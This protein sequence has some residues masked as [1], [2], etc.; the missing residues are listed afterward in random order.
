MA[1]RIPVAGLPVLLSILQ[2]CLPLVSMADSLSTGGDRG[3]LKWWQEARFGMF[4]HWGPVSLAGTEIGWSRGDQVSTE[5]YD[6]LYRRFNPT[7]FD[8]RAWARLAKEAG[9]KY[10]VFTTKHHDGFCNWDTKQTDYNILQTPFGRDVVK[11][12]AS[13]CRAE[14][15]TFCAYHSICDWRH[16]DY[17][18]GSPGGRTEKPQPNMDRYNAYLKSQLAELIQN[19]GPLG[20][21]WF[22]GEW[23]KPWNA[24]RGKDLYEFCR[25]L[26][27][28]L[29]INN[30]VSVGRSGMA[31]ATDSTAD[32]PGDYDTPEQEIGKYQD[33]RPWETCMTICRQWAW[34][35]NDELKSL[36]E[37]LQTLIVCTAGDGNLLFNVGPMPDGQ[38]EPRQV[39]RLK[40]MGAWLQTYGN[41][42]YGTR[43]GPWKPA[44]GVAST[45]RDNRVFLHILRG[46]PESVVLPD[47]PGKV[48]RAKA[49]TGG[50]V[51][52]TQSGGQITL[53]LKP[54][55]WTPERGA[56]GL[57]RRGESKVAGEHIDTIIA[58]ELD[59]SAMDI[60]AME[61]PIRTAASASNTFQNQSDYSADKAFDGNPGT[62]WATDS[63]TTAA[64][65]SLK[66]ATPQHLGKV[67]IQEAYPGRVQQF[68]LMAE[69]GTEWKKV[70]S[71]T[72][73]GAD[74][75][76]SFS[77]V[78][79]SGLRLNILKATDGPTIKEIE[80]WR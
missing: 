68:E 27:P 73:L 35:P 70:S 5:V 57:L 39:A 67:R 66:F 20:I 6:G 41:T 52:V 45:R 49:L 10:L 32:N 36:R 23:E 54:K 80:F 7:N 24:Q 72:T 1:M 13:A 17:P 40:Q 55:T 46:S 8:A 3:R 75:R 44:A 77:P 48:L 16:P 42:I 60:P 64:W 22:D 12:L 47:L 69:M 61:T 58:L 31:G 33:R 63:G 38:I 18:L 53:S 26:Q 25:K 14:G 15:I 43:G 30:R 51:R 65:V 56:E 79:A 71:G 74:Y 59:R 50:S 37:C 9:M 28:S 78:V 21:L 76:C 11:E 19:Y 2:T 34:K 29:I 62:R 4:V